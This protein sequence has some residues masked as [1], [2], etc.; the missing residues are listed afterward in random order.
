MII[1]S[2]NLN[3]LNINFKEF[4]STIKRIRYTNKE[5]F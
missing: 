1:C 5:K 4:I 2:I 3:Y